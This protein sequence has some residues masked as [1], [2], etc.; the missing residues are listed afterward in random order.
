[1][2]MTRDDIR[3]TA[4]TLAHYWEAAASDKDRA[5]VVRLIMTHEDDIRPA[6]V[7]AM[8][9]YLLARDAGYSALLFEIELMGL[10]GIDEGDE[11][12]RDAMRALADLEMARQ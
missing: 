4:S 3:N 5:G 11:E 1:M 8:A 6:L 10:A 12:E 9:R 2:H 7:V